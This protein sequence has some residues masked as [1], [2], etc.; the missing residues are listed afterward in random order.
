[1]E[2]QLEEHTTDNKYFNQIKTRGKCSKEMIVWT[3]IHALK[4]MQADKKNAV[5][6][7]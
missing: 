5:N 7:W 4:S 1:M 3:P 6:D 2:I